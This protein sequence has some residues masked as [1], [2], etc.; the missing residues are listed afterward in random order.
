MKVPV[1]WL[2]DYV[3]I[4]ATP[5]EIAEKLTFAGIELEGMERI[6]GAYSGLVVGEVRAVEPHPNADKL[7]VCRVFDGKDEVQVVCGAPNVEAG[8]RYPFAPVGAMLDNGS[9]KI[10]KAKLRGVESFGML[11]SASELGISDDHDGLMVLDP[12]YTAGTPMD[13]VL[14]PP[15]TVL[16]LE[17]TPNR[18]DCLS[19]IGIARELAGIYGVPLEMPAVDLQETDIPV[20]DHASVSVDDTE[21]CGRYTA[22]VV[23]D[24]AIR[25]S[26]SWMQRRL[27]LS[28]IRAINNIVDITN[29]VMLECGHPLHAFD[30]ALLKDSTV[31]VR[32]AAANE[33]MKTLD[34]IDRELQ[35]DTL[36]IADAE[37][38][39]AL[40]GIMGG[41]GSEIRDDTKDVLLESARFDPDLIRATARR[42]GLSTESSYRF[43]RG[44]DP[45]TVEWASR[46]A[47]SLLASLA[48][49]KIC[50]GVIDVYP[51]PP[52]VRQVSCRFDRTRDLL[53]ADIPDE[54]IIA[55]LS[56]LGLKPQEISG[57]ACVLEIPS[58]RGDLER[59]VDLIEEVARRFGLDNI[60]SAP[61]AARINVDADDTPWRHREDLRGE[62]T[63]L[64]LQEITTYSLVPEGLLNL[65]FGPGEEGRIALPRPVTMDQSILRTSLVPQMVETLG[66]NRSR[67]TED[68]ALYEM[69]RVYRRNQD[70]SSTETIRLAAGVMGVPGGNSIRTREPVTAAG[71]YGRIK[72]LWEKLAERRP[73]L[74]WTLRPCE[75]PWFEPGHAAEIE[76]GGAVVARFGVI[77]SGIRKEWRLQDPVAVLD[78][79]A[80]VLA[81]SG[82]AMPRYQALPTYPSVTRDLAMITGHDVRHE[83]I[84]EIIRANSPDELETVELFDVFAGKGIPEGRKS[85]AYSLTYRAA[86]RTLTDD[87]TNGYLTSVMDA[88]RNVLHADIRDR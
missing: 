27:E 12:E 86:G 39:V 24:I 59:E 84:L 69:G 48:D 44:V 77:A 79:D 20:T 3:K 13:T 82:R 26:P 23:R 68:A 76:S 33:S 51:N 22:R 41:A 75:A 45:E 52:N 25:P 65:F 74:T 57:G 62:M 8:G 53:G 61:V 66:R 55:I 2:L 50:R 1:S 73:G 81:S 88:L 11:C 42:L 85:M 47:A 83:D 37:G 63:A 32:R 5:E 6:G 54:N 34:D 58:Y 64:G 7:R 30:K 31:I 78:A 38:P 87:E 15:E 40:A 70:G 4:T 60:P 21:G 17:V 35:S 67:Q 56:S 28:G 19:M 29:Y 71:M 80:D 36:V 46:R 9:F 10:K 18:P 72:G 43:E 16:E 49:G 14:G